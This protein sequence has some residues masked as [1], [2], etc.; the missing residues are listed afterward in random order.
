MSA[1]AAW[2]AKKFALVLLKVEC[3]FLAVYALFK[4][5]LCSNSNQL[6]NSHTP[7]SWGR[8]KAIPPW[9]FTGI[10][11]KMHAVG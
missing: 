1:K 4:P 8:P 5:R 2:L 10:L 9:L 11:A 6:G 7:A 3:T